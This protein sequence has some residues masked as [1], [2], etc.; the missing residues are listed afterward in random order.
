MTSEELRE[1]AGIIEMP[2]CTS[3]PSLWASP[4]PVAFPEGPGSVH[5]TIFLLQL[6]IQ[7]MCKAAD[8]E[9]T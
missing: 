9:A 7:D 8:T 6:R 2:T 3:L 4:N 5:L 1:E